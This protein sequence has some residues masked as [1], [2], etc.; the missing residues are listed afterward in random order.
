MRFLYA[1]IALTFWAGLIAYCVSKGMQN[2]SIDIQLVTSA[3][4]I[5][6]ALAGGD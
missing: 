1:V 2:P 3:I 6:G 5:A 4:I